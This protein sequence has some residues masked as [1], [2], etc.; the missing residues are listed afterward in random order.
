MKRS[1]IR[2]YIYHKERQVKEWH[3]CLNT[4]CFCLT[5][6]IFNLLFIQWL[7]IKVSLKELQCLLYIVQ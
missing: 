4:F 1:V 3:R 5:L 2:M 6:L 7:Y